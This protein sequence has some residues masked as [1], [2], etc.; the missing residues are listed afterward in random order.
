MDIVVA[1]G[2]DGTVNE[3][4]RSLVHTKT[5]LGIL[6]CGSGNGLARHLM[7]PMNLRKSI[8][9]INRCEIHDLDYGVVNGHPFFCTCGM[10]FDADISQKFA[11]SG[12]RGPITYVQKVLEEG[13]KY[14]PQVYE[15]EIRGDTTLH[16]SDLI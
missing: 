16:K 3:V 6:P 2:G 8:E 4:A 10:G 13:L 9:V 5:A 14:K 12:K 15:L 1:V 11:E 7:L